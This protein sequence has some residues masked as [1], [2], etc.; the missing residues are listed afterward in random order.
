MMKDMILV[1]MNLPLEASTMVDTITEALFYLL[2]FISC[3]FME[4]FYPSI[5]P[6]TSPLSCLVL[7][8]QGASKPEF[9]VILKEFI[10]MNRPSI[11]AFSETRLDGNHASKL[12]TDIGLLGHLS[13]DTVG[14]SGGIWLYWNKDDA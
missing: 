4:E 12:T 2:P 3:Y 11:V 9:K 1:S 6:N 8:V 13:V 10:R 14:F 7:N 5:I